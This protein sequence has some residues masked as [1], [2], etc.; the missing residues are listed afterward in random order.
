MITDDAILDLRLGGFLSNMTMREFFRDCLVALMRDADGFSGK[1]P[2]CDSGWLGCFEEALV[3]AHVV[4]GKLT[5]F[6]DGE[7]K[8]IIV[9]QTEFDVVMERIIF[10]ALSPN[11]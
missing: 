11:A 9:N 8:D 10:H 1:R 4:D 7:V 6:A 3:E 5:Y 2:I